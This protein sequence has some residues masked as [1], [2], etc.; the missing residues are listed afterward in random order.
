[1][2]AGLWLSRFGQHMEERNWSWHT[3]AGYTSAVR[4][5]FDFL[6]S[7]GVASV[8]EITRE[9]VVAFR[10][11]LHHFVCRRTGMHLAMSTQAINLVAVRAFCRFLAQERYVLLD[12]SATVD[13]PKVP[14]ALPRALLGEEDVLRLLHAPDVHEPLGL[15]DR[16]V[17]E[18]L[19]GTGLRNSELC[20]LDCEDLELG[21]L[22]LHVFHGKGQCP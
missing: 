6:A 14:D 22:E 19:Y 10:S 18:V 13:V 1:M 8:A 4:R 20:A 21:E 2:D 16:A 7:Q 9:T 12:A 3:V 5:F 11:F 15:R 17:L